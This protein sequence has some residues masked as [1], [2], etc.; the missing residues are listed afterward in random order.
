M[1]KNKTIKEQGIIRPFV[2]TVGT[3][4]TN[5]GGGTFR[6][7]DVYSDES[8]QMVNTATGW[9]LTVHTIQRYPDGTIEWDYSTGGHWT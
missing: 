7:V 8:A 1:N 5:R 4:Y 3:V 2:P 6:C 9:R